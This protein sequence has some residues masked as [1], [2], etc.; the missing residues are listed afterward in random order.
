MCTARIVVALL[1]AFLLLAAP[2]HARLK[3]GD[4]L[5]KSNWQEAQDLFPAEI[6]NHSKNGEFVSPVGEIKATYA[7][8]PSVLEAGEK[9]EGKY[10]IDQHGSVVETAT[11]K[12]PEY[13]FG[14][15]FSPAKLDP[16]DPNVA[17]KI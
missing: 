7:L 5:D 3:P 13:N 11:G 1:A 15:P 14:L 9:N 16:K 17:L 10:K 4:T 2:A 8:D 12:L 6:L